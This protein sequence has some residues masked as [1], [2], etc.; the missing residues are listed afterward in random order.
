MSGSLVADGQGATVRA[1]IAFVTIASLRVGIAEENVTWG[2]LYAVQPFSS[3][4]LSMIIV[5]GQVRGVLKQEWEAPLS[6]S[7]LSYTFDER[8]S[9][10]S[11][12]FEI[13]VDGPRLPLEYSPLV[14]L[15]GINETAEPRGMR[16]NRHPRVCTL[17]MLQPIHGFPPGC[18]PG[19][20]S[21]LN[22]LST[23]Y[24]YALPRPLG[25]GVTKKKLMGSTL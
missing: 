10:G 1:G 22:V 12:I 5:G 11:R 23:A 17:L 20:A 2:D 8:K 21:A 7:G 15:H 14:N 13:R 24:Y 6:V 25:V 9:T 19:D 4:V 16:Q 3:T 18:A